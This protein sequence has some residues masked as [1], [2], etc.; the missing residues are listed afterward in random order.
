[1]TFRLFINPDNG[2]FTVE[3]FATIEQAAKRGATIIRLDD[4]DWPEADIVSLL[5]AG[6]ALTFHDYSEIRLEEVK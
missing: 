4:P 3:D 2:D 6:K 1:M 5:K